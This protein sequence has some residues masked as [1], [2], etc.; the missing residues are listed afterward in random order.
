MSS[1]QAP[2]APVSELAPGLHRIEL[3]GGFVSAYLLDGDDGLV[4]VD[5][6]PPESA[7]P[8]LGALRSL[9]RDA[10]SLATIL[11]THAH[12]DHSGSA[13]A[14]RDATGARVLMSHLDAELIASG[15]ASRGLTFLPG[16]EETIPTPP[17]LTLA[18]LVEPSPIDAFEV[19]GHLEA[20]AVP[21]VQG[22]EAI[23]A[24][25]HCAGQM[26]VLWNRHGGVLICGDA[27]TNFG[28]I[29]IA[30]VGEDL[31]LSRKSAADLSKREFEIATF[32]HGDPVVGGAAATLRAALA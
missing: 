8:I 12:A 6:G 25:G 1:P 27:V 23:P 9:G 24:P 4:L 18:D 7:G 26:A 2:S 31:D 29:A 13:A 3:G 20:G 15:W 30:P 11:V 32:G 16:A 5:S 22:I 14:L 21:G 10:S 17:G 28:E 19:D